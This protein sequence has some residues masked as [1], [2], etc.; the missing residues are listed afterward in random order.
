MVENR[1]LHSL[2]IVRMQYFAKFK[3]LGSHPFIHASCIKAQHY[4]YI[5]IA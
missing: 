4:P 2:F 1:G 3:R 5:G